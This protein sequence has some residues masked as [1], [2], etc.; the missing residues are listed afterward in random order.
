MLP[1][2]LSLRSAVLSFAKYLVSTSE[3]LDIAKQGGRGID[4]N[5]QSP[6]SDRTSSLMGQGG[7]RPGGSAVKH[8]PT[9]AGDTGD[10][11]LGGEDPLK[12]EMAAHSS[13]LAPKIPR[14]EEPGGYRPWGC[15][16]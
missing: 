6:G 2:G 4:S 12:E 14:T 15:K 1:C 5:S 10:E 8:P 11:S 9:K 16:E 7:G 3:V 13:I